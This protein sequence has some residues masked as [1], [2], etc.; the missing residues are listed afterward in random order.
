MSDMYVGIGLI[1]FLAAVIFA[2]TLRLTRTIPRVLCDLLGMLTV[3]AMILYIR[4]FFDSLVTARL[5]PFS[6]V[7]VVGNWFPLAASLL[8]GLAWHRIPGT[9][10]RKC[11]TVIP[12]FLSGVYSLYH[13]LRGAPPAC[14]QEYSEGIVRQTTSSTCSPACAATLLRHY[15]IE[16]TEQEMA[17]LCLT[18][19]GTHWQGLY[20]GLSLKTAGTPWQVEVLSCD[21]D[22]LTGMLT[23]PMIM[24]VQ[25]AAD[26]NAETH[27]TRDWGW[28]P[29]QSHSAVLFGRSADG[30]FEVG[31]PANGRESWSVDDLQVLW[32]GRGMRL[33]RREL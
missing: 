28:V 31:D 21:V 25:L 5:L 11:L 24:T 4:D 15:G 33:V 27:Y 18:R 20:R 1:L 16:A 2:V 12:L 32:A 8:A 19:K 3:L 13:P 6:N 14:D 26:V 9:S 29:G 23:G 22:N 30:K 17:E 10:P 7:I